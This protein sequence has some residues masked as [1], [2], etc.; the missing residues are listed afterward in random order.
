MEPYAEEFHKSQLAIKD[1]TAKAF[2]GD[3]EHQGRTRHYLQ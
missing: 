2:N 1:V 3:K